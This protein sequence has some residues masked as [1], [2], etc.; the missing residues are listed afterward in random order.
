MQKNC[1]LEHATTEVNAHLAMKIDSYESLTTRIGHLRLR[2]CDSI[3]VLTIFSAYRPTSFYEEEL[4]RLLHESSERKECRLRVSEA[5]TI[6][7][8][9]LATWTTGNATGARSGKSMINGTTDDT[10]DI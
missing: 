5:R 6:R 8:I 4:E 2:R 9:W 7:W 1:F 10:D 3:A